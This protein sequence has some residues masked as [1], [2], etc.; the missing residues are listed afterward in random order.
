MKLSF[1]R[2][3][4]HESIEYYTL[5]SIIFSVIK[6]K[7]RSKIV[8]KKIQIKFYALELSNHIILTWK[9]KIHPHRSKS[10][11]DAIINVR[12]SIFHSIMVVSW[13]SPF[14]FPYVC[15]L[16]F[17][18]NPQKFYLRWNC[19]ER[20]FSIIEYNHKNLIFTHSWN[21]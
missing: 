14:S 2:W 21:Y 7:T 9:K 12:Y 16:I 5:F 1:T 4:R 15:N 3:Q 18:T 8:K 20:S 17:Q 10:K 11:C 19:V 13:F 6:S